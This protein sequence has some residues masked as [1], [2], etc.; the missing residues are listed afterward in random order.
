MFIFDIGNLLLTKQRLNII[1]DIGVRDGLQHITNTMIDMREKNNTGEDDTRSLL[2]GLTAENQATLQSEDMKKDVKTEIIL[3][4]RRNWSTLDQNQEKNLENKL[5]IQHFPQP[6][7]QKINCAESGGEIH[8][9]KSSSSLSLF[10]YI[11]ES[12]IM[13]RDTG[14]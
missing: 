8:G 4:L 6:N 11:R 12:D 2:E 1:L 13:D 10:V 3:S 5:V 14:K 9:N 7:N